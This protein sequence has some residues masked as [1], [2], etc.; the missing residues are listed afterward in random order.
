MNEESPESHYRD[1]LLVD[2]EPK[3][4]LLIG[5][6]LRANGFD[7]IT[8]PDALRAMQQLDENRVGLVILDINIAGEDGIRLMSFM[9]LN[10]PDLPV[11]LYT[12]L[13]HDEAQVQWMFAQGAACYVSKAVPPSDLLSAVQQILG[14][15]KA[16]A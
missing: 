5:D 9:K 16:K 11:M 15:P 4:L 6:L 3:L 1:V 8:A 10:H 12:G 14:V 13:S 2:D 7:V